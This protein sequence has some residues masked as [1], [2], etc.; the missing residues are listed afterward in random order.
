MS[1]S[2]MDLKGEMLAGIF[3]YDAHARACFAALNLRH[4]VEADLWQLVERR[5]VVIGWG[6]RVDG[7]SSGS[8]IKV[9]R[10]GPLDIC[11]LARK[12]IEIGTNEFARG[13]AQ[14]ETKKINRGRC[15]GRSGRN[16]CYAAHG[17]GI[18]VERHFLREDFAQIEIVEFGFGA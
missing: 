16:S 13:V 14:G 1:N 4:G 12:P 2:Q 6:G 18:D 3:E 9:F 17:I 10:F 8:A 11:G 7:T 15:V 5:E